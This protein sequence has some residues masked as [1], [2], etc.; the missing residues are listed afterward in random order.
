MRPDATRQT[1]ARPAC[2]GG[3]P[4]FPE[5]RRRGQ[6]EGRPAARPARRSRD[7]VYSRVRRSWRPPKTR[8]RQK[9]LE[10]EKKQAG[11][12]GPGEVFFDVLE[13]F[14]R[15]LAGFEFVN[16]LVDA[17]ERLGVLGAIKFAAAHVGDFLQGVLVDVDRN[18]GVGAPAKD[19]AGRKLG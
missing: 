15:H 4:R 5:A 12:K 2:D 7:R 10:A 19:V 11:V 16:F 13:M 3:A 14:D 8:M 1:S 17:L 9:D 18:G 6:P